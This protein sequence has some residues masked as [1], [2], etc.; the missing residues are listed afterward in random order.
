MDWLTIF[1]LAIV[2]ALI[3]SKLIIF[4]KLRNNRRLRIG[5]DVPIGNLADS[6]S[7]GSELE[8]KFGGGNGGGAGTTRS[9]SATAA[10]SNARIITVNSIVNGEI[11]GNV[12]S[13]KISENLLSSS[14]TISNRIEPTAAINNVANLLTI[15]VDA[16]EVSATAF[17][18]ITDT[19]GN[20]V[21]VVGE[22]A[23]AVGEVVGEI[24]SEIISN[25]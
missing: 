19:A 18:F 1:L 10:E 17:E 5:S 11:T 8:T 2:A 20:A 3:I 4:R 14:D 22:A 6:L 21:E 12:V 24:V 9:F 25:N 7:I 16:E 23:G 13:D 15:N